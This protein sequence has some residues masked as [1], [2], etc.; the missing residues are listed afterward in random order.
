MPKPKFTFANLA[1]LATLIIAPLG[2][3]IYLKKG[4]NY[5]LESLDQLAPL[6]LS[7]EVSDILKPF[8]LD[9]GNVK[10]IHFNQL[11]DAQAIELLYQLDERIV[12]KDRLDII[13]LGTD[14]RQGRNEHS[15]QFVDAKHGVGSSHSFALFDTSNVARG[16]YELDNE[17]G[18]KLIRHLSVLIPLPKQR[19]EIKLKRDI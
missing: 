10:L 2:S 19:K 11:E 5:R 8:L 12:D 13:S 4:I 15:I 17:T 7:S 9:T 16:L 6:Q 14:A 1:L 18:K 3:Y